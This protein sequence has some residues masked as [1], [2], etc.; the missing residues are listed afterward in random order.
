MR[1]LVAKKRTNL[2]EP[3]QWR[4]RHD[5][6]PV[7]H[8]LDVLDAAVET[9]DGQM[10]QVAIRNIVDL[11]DPTHDVAAIVGKAIANTKSGREDPASPELWYWRDAFWVKAVDT[12]GVEYYRN[13]GYLL[14]RV[15][16][17]DSAELLSKLVVC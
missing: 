3:V 1:K 9:D 10:V 6:K 15:E 14:Y 4:L 8:R 5:C 7:F 17:R 16:V 13:K 12:I 11:A 2:Q